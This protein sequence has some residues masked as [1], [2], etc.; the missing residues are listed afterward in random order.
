MK[1]TKQYLF[2]ALV[3][4][5]VAA[6]A[7]PQWVLA[8]ATAPASNNYTKACTAITN[9]AN[10][11]FSVNG[12]AQPTG[13]SGVSSFIVGNKINLVVQ[14]NDAADVTVLPGS[15]N[16]PLSFLL[17]NTG[18]AKQQ[19]M[20]TYLSQS[21]GVLSPTSGVADSMD[22][23]NPG[24]G[25]INTSTYT[26][27]DV[28]PDTSITVTINAN[29]PAVPAN[30]AIAVYTLVAETRK[31][32]SGAVE[33]G[34]NSTGAITDSTG[35]TC[36]ADIVYANTVVSPAS[37]ADGLVARDAKASARSAY[38]TMSAVLS[39]SKAATT[40][41]DPINGNTSPKAIPGALIRYV[42]TIANAAGSA[43][44]TL[45]TVSD[46]LGGSMTLD[47]D[48]RVPAVCGSAPCALTALA[49]ESMVGSGFKASVSGGTRVG[50]S[51]GLVNG[52]P[53]YFTTASDA[54]GVEFVS[55]L[56]TLTAATL[57]PVD[58]GGGTPYTAG[59]LKAGETLTLTFDVTVN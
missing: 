14:S 44:A 49:A 5:G 6:L 45:T 26:T 10:I 52:T 38:K 37:I 29:A 19:Y 8:A 17:S 20:L 31:A 35:A 27:V 12:A 30:G 2:R 42:V 34:N 47:P 4:S 39:F 22:M 43:S 1:T 28:N 53:K 41:W 3:I 32:G 56:I 46:T 9:V 48:L 24:V 36:S 13:H 33:S 58:A 11:E 59:E 15:T 50:T 57:L 54:D 51:S 7:A 23:L 25:S 40:I 55:P 21:S 16:Q 18:N